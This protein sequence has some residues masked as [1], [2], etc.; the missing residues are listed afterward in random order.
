MLLAIIADDLT[1][2]ADAAATFATRGFATSIAFTA[3]TASD[4]DVVV[5]STESRDGDLE[6]A[7][8]AVD[9]A[10][11]ALTRDSNGPTPAFIY[12]K[13]DSVLRG[14]P[15]EEFFALLRVTGERRALLTPALP[16]EGRRTVLGRHFVNGTPLEA[17]SFGG[18]GVTSDLARL[19]R[20][21]EFG[22][23]RLLDLATIRAGT[24]NIA[25]FLE[26]NMDGIVIADAETDEDL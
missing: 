21:D 17:S 2:A 8:S 23:V 22:G 13:I 16:S 11:N 20:N 1:G 26:A 7:V 24:G 9:A 5:R 14:H 10:T 3:E 19:F 6:S 18:P 4:L 15:R 12:K 25:G